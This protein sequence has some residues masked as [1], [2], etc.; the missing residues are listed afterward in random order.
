MKLRTQLT[1]LLILA[2]LLVS[3]ALA[4]SSPPQSSADPPNV[5]KTIDTMIG[6]NSHSEVRQLVVDLQ[7]AVARHDPT[8]V[9]ALVRYPIRVKLHGKPTYINTPKAF[10]K[11]Y[12]NII[13]PDIAAV[14]ENQKYETLFV[15]YQGAM[16]GEGEVWITGQ[17]TDNTCK[18]PDIKI[19][20]IQSTIATSEKSKFR[21]GT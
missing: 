14:I 11:N 15:N 20:T 8:A 10:I 6:E 7:Q 5:D 12:D 21:P 19:G 18:H 1:R 3:H 16:F 17:C 2:G 4:Q 9:A 13:T